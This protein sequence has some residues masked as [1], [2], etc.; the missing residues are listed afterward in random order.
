MKETEL[1]RI[2][3]R[4]Y[5]ADLARTRTVEGTGLGLSIVATIVKLHGGQIIVNSKEK[6]GSTFIVEIPVR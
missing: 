2:F 6:I 4:F 5:R 1:N 3:D